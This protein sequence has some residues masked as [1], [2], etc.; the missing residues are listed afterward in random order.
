MDKSAFMNQFASRKIDVPFLRLGAICVMAL[1]SLS[2]FSAAVNAQ[3]VSQN[4]PDT[5][6]VPETVL[7]GTT[8]GPIEWRVVVAEKVEIAD[9]DHL[10][11]EIQKVLDEVNARMSTYLP[12]SDV[13]RFN[14]AKAGEWV[15]VDPDVVTV[16]Q[17]ARA[18][19]LATGGA[20]DITVG[21]AVN[22]WS[23]GPDDVESIPTD[24]E[25]EELKSLVGFS[26]VEIR[27]SPA[28]IRK[29]L[30][31]L[32]IDLSAIAK[33]Y[34][35]D[36]VADRLI[37]LGI[38]NAMVEVGGEVMALG[39]KTA[40][41][42]WRIGI[43]APIAGVRRIARVALLSDTAMATSGDYRNFRI[44]GGQK[45]SHTIDPRTCRPVENDMALASIVAP[46]CMTADALATAAMV[47]GLEDRDADGH[48]DIFSIVRNFDGTG[49]FVRH[50]GAGFAETWMEEFPFSEDG[51][52]VTEAVAESPS[53]WPAFGAAVAIF[54]LAVI[55]MAVGAIFG[56]RPIQGSCGGIAIREGDDG[57]RACGLCQKPVSECPEKAKRDSST[58]G[59]DSE[60]KTDA[61][62]T[63]V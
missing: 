24:D 17:R 1:L 62:S 11:T 27:Q 32:Q 33:G 21:P 35:V 23:F 3:A 42:P 25:L 44:V 10:Q 50:D 43:E 7:Q 54:L 52:T 41:Q 34:A 26:K 36:R 18:I 20:F 2:V 61:T 15:L 46:D 58:A 19:F 48:E 16:V 63:P 57:S 38:K 30:D 8:M 59:G 45:I 55:A 5:S 29:S 22:R 28:A 53:I 31:G 9:T 12:D 60:R 47:I 49:Y 56:N 4:A 40:G 14:Q 6:G 13:T 51:P 39:H 37:E